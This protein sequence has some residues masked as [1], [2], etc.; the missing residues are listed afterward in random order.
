MRSHPSRS[1]AQ[2]SRAS[3]GEPSMPLL[4]AAA[5]VVIAVVAAV[6]VFGVQSP[7][8]VPSLGATQ[9]P[10]PQAAVAWLAHDGA[11]TCVRIAWP[12]GSETRPWCDDAGGEVVG[13]GTAGISVS[14][15]SGP[16]ARRLVID[17]RTGEV[18]EVRVDPSFRP[19][20]PSDSTVGTYREG[21]EQVVMLE[22]R[23]LWRVEAPETYDVRSSSVSPDGRWVA[24]VDEAER[25]L[26]VP[27]DGSAPPQLWAGEVSTWGPLVWQGAGV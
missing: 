27:S 10:S 20:T 11:E 5:V 22:D 15:Y 3:T 26:V 19:H 24:M 12:D 2:G 14:D 9:Q 1:Q 4:V 7:P 18:L 16:A 13:W 8:Q 17:P 6:L 21:G 23:E 25:L